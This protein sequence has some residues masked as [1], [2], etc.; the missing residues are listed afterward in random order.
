M[1][2][3][4]KSEKLDTFWKQLK[5]HFSMDIMKIVYKTHRNDIYPTLRKD[6]W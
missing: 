3:V 4:T 2:D 1:Y 6:R 5:S